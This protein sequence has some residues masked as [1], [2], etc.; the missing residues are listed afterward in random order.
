MP[1]PASHHRFPAVAPT[2]KSPHSRWCVDLCHFSS[3]HVRARARSLSA[4]AIQFFAY[5]YL[6]SALFGGEGGG[7]ASLVPLERLTAGALAGAVAQ[8]V[9]H[10]L[11][12]MRARVT[13]DMRGTEARRG[14]V[15][16]LVRLYRREGVA[17][18]YRGLAPSLMGI[19]PYV[20]LVTAPEMIELATYLPRYD[21]PMIG[22]R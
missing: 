7:Q 10:P 4:S 2:A 3:R 21:L 16:G 9:T 1:R 15:G 14:L 19:M 20:S 12:V 22:D 6:K 8:G 11:D 17:A 13:A 5:D 18:C